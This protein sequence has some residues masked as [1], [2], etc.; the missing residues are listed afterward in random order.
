MNIKP[1]RREI[2]EEMEDFENI[3]DEIRKQSP[4][5]DMEH[6]AAPNAIPTL[7]KS[8]CSKGIPDFK[9]AVAV[10]KWFQS[11]KEEL[12]TW[13][14]VNDYLQKVKYPQKGGYSTTKRKKNRG[15]W[16]PRYI[17]HHSESAE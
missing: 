11:L 5:P 7:N 3:A 8:E 12:S 9:D 2:L 1:H 15:D 14:A 4:D 17:K 13:A 6:V 16:I 10:A